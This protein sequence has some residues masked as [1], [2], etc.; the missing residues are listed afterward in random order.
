[1]SEELNK[2]QEPIEDK[3]SAEE[4]SPTSSSKSVQSGLATASV[5]PSMTTISCKNVQSSMHEVESQ[6]P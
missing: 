3:D 5:T 4:L 1:M 6:S 2:R